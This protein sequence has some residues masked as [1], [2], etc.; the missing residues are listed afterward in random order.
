LF[1]ELVGQGGADPTLTAD[2]RVSEGQAIEF[3]VVKNR[4]W[5]KR[6]FPT[7][8]G[9]AILGPSAGGHACNWKLQVPP[10]HVSLHVRFDPTGQR[11]LMWWL[12]Q[13]RHAAL[14]GNYALIG[15]WSDWQTLYSFHRSDEYRDMFV[16]DVEVPAARDIAFQI[17]CNTDLRQ[18]I[19]PTPF[20]DIISGIAETSH[21][22][23]WQMQ[24]PPNKALL[25][26]YFDP[27]GRRSL[28]YEF[29]EREGVALSRT[30]ALIG[31]WDRWTSLHEFVLDETHG[32]VF[33]A[34]LEVSG[35]DPIEFQIVCNGDWN[36][37]MY[38]S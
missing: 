16:A 7:P 4:D 5:N 20:G 36:R 28:A 34:E 11:S 22:L 2:I 35:N 38:P 29:C 25:R 24:V 26:L 17:V 9:N 8:E 3:Q 21:G 18:R 23:N 12:G 27:V 37:R 1:D 30:Y 33:V 32:K 13:S 14:E 15:S 10:D 31:S 19:F 6:I